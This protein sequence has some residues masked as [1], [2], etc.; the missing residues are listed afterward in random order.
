MKP[1]KK[2][3]EPVGGYLVPRRALRF[4]GSLAEPTNRRERGEGNMKTRSGQWGELC[5]LRATSVGEHPVLRD[6]NHF[7]QPTLAFGQRG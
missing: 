4:D 2:S 1:N 3:P 7:P 5:N 6:S